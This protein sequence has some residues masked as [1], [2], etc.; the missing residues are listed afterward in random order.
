MSCFVPSVQV[1]LAVNCAVTPNE[2]DVLPGVTVIEAMTAGV[3]ERVV[4]PLTPESEAVTVVEP[5][6]FVVAAPVLEIVATLVS[7]EVQVAEWVRSR[8]ELSL[9]LPVAVNC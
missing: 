6:V 7:E 2:I 4:L 8:L 5:V 3:T 1:A 9:N